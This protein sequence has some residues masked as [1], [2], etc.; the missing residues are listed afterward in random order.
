M[1]C[2][3]FVVLLSVYR[4]SCGIHKVADFMA[5][6]GS[7]SRVPASIDRNADSEHIL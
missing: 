2:D 7:G 5:R 4:L 6:E 3:V 1:G